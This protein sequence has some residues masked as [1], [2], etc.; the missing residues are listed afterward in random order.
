MGPE[1][2]LLVLTAAAVGAAVGTFT[3]LVPGI[4]VNTLAA[5]LFTSYPAV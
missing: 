1:L 3:G 4:H 2:L 5:V